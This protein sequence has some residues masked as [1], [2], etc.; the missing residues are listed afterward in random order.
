MTTVCPLC[1][2]TVVEA[3][4]SLMMGTVALLLISMLELAKELLVAPTSILTK[5]SPVMRGVTVRFTPTSR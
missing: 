1:T 4:R 3:R 2:V 5:P